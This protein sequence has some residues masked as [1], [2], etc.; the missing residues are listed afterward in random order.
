[1]SARRVLSLVAVLVALA[2]PRAARAEWVEGGVHVASLPGRFLQDA[3]R[4]AVGE[5]PSPAHAKGTVLLAQMTTERGLV[6]TEWDLASAKVVRQA[7]LGV[8]GRRPRIV[9]SGPLLHIATADPRARY[10]QVDAATLRVVHSTDLGPADEAEIASDAGVTV[11]VWSEDKAWGA[12]RIDSDGKIAAHMRRESAKYR[13]WS[14]LH[15]AVSAGRVFIDDERTLTALSPDLVPQ[16]SVAL[17][18]AYRAPFVVARGSLI[19]ADRT[20]LV[21][22]SPDLSTITPHSTGSACRP[23]VPVDFECDS[24]GRVAGDAKGRVAFESGEV[25]AA[26]GKPLASFRIPFPTGFY[27]AVDAFWV[28]DV[29]VFVRVSDPMGDIA[30]VVWFDLREPGAQPTVPRGG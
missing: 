5:L 27:Y 17:D 10:V 13:S 11:V 25:F 21:E 12:A 26:T 1:M 29:P 18:S 28:G 2:T 15:V 4:G 3:I 22:V 7:A 14:S 6:V 16:G 30:Q 20:T 8:A 9:R 24:P 19:F 23:T